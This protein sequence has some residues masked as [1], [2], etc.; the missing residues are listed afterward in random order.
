MWPH[1]SAPRSRLGCP[2]C[3]AVASGCR[4]RLLAGELKVD[5]LRSLAALVGLGIEGH[6][7]ALIE[8]TNPRPLDGGDVHEHILP[9]LVRRDEAEALRLIKELN[10]SRLPHVVRPPGPRGNCG[11]R[12]PTGARR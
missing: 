11:W 6:A 7:H 12:A 1:C 3:G 2:R 5:R 9:A 8:R 10:R 4:R